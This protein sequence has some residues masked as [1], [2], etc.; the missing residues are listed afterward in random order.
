[1]FELEVVSATSVHCARVRAMLLRARTAPGASVVFRVDEAL[2]DGDGVVDMTL[3]AASAGETRRSWQLLVTM[4]STPASPAGGGPSGDG[5]GAEWCPVKEQPEFAQV[6]PAL[7]PHAKHLLREPHETTK[8]GGARYYVNR[9]TRKGSVD[10]GGGEDEE[11]AA[12]A[13]AASADGG[14]WTRALFEAAAG[15]LRVDAACITDVTF[16]AQPSCGEA[17]ATTSDHPPL[18]PDSEAAAAAA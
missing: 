14:A 1:M 17:S 13:A 5:G 6:P 9:R 7:V 16:F 11:A 8:E 3:P 2:R 12:A 10:A 18:P 4:T 15:I